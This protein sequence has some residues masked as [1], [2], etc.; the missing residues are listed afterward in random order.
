MDAT[1]HHH[2]LG[3][4]WTVREPLARSSHALVADGRLWLVD[5][6]D[7]EE[8]LDAAL[9]L[10][11]APAA[12]L[13]VL[14]RHPRDSAAIAERLGIPHHRL[15]D[16][17]PGTPFRVVP[18][19]DVP[20]WREHA[21]WWAERRALVVPEAVGTVGYFAVGTGAV[22]VHPFL[23]PL[24]PRSLAQF[25][26]E[27]LL[28]GHGPPRS[29]PETADELRDALRRSRRDLVRLPGALLRR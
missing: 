18:V 23:R 1:L 17:L 5:P 6:V 14:D 16:H 29:G 25:E 15:P 10:G 7:H 12:V 28:V 26:P 4:T 20:G 9:A 21:L 22:G 3:L 11:A 8:A 2:P 19:V 27:H 24:P 13:Q